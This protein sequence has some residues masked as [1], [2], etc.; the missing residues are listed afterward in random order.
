[1][2]FI[3]AFM[4]SGLLSE[5]HAQQWIYDTNP[6][7]IATAHERSQYHVAD[8]IFPTGPSEFLKEAKREAPTVVHAHGCQGISWDEHYLTTFFKEN[9]A[10]VVLLDFLKRGVDASC[11][12]FPRVGG[13]PEVSNPAR[14]AARR[15]ELEHQVTWLKQQGFTNIYVSGHSEGGRTVQAVQQDVKAVFISGMDCKPEHMRFW[16]PRKTNKIMVFLSRRDAWL[17]YPQSRIVGCSHF[18]NSSHVIEYWTDVPS[19]SPV[20]AFSDWKDIV[21]QALKQ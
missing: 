18:F 13:W 10:N 20:S 9:G 14:I 19:H 11:E 12:T 7:V 17:N 2:R 3:V 4:L 8:G 16:S 5:V 1:M 15:L 21:K 6:A